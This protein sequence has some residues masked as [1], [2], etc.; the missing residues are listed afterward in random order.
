MQEF[1]EQ[2]GSSDENEADDHLVELTIRPTHDLRRQLLRR[3]SVTMDLGPVR[4]LLAPLYDDWYHECVECGRSLDDDTYYYVERALRRGEPLFEY[5]LCEDCVYSLQDDISDESVQ[6]ITNYWLRHYDLDRRTA[7][8]SDGK[9]ALP[10]LG[11]CVFTQRPTEEIE[12]YQVWAW[13]RGGRLSVDDFAP[14]L[15]STT[16]IEQ[17]T[18]LLS[19]K[20]RERLDDFVRDRLGLP[21]ELQKL[22]LIL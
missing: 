22:P 19:Q 1:D 6:T 21:P 18:E 14:A 12:E 13:M 17:V 20:T 7:L 8:R 4:E 5:A 16:A 15:C 2:P 10:L 3:E 9:S 11:E